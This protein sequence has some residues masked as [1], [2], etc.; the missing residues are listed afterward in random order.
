MTIK[1]TGIPRSVFFLLF[2][3]SGFAGLIYESIWSHY[4]KLFLGHAAYAQTLVLAIFMG[5]MALGARVCAAYTQRWRN[6]LLG[7]AVAELLI[8]LFA[9]VFH[10]IFVATTAFAYDSV[11]PALGNPVAIDGFKWALAALL[12]LPQSVLL[13]MTFPLM[14]GGIIR[15]YPG[16]PGSSL[17]MLY[18]TNSLGAAIG[19]LASGFY[20]LDKVGMPGTLLTA[21]LMNVGLALCVWGICKSLAAEGAPAAAPQRPL[22]AGSGPAERT[23]LYMML[24][25]SL[26]S[27]A[28]SFCYEIGWI[29]MLSLVLGSSTHAFEL[30]LSAFILGIAFGGLWIKKR[31]D[32]YRSIVG[33]L[34]VVLVAKGVLALATLPVYANTFEVMRLTMKSLAKTDFAYTVFNLT[35]HLISLSVMF[36]AAF[37][38]GMSLP[39]ITFALLSKG[40]GESSIGKVYAWNTLGAI[41]GVMFAVHVAMPFMGLKALIIAGAVADIAVALALMWKLDRTASSLKW[42]AASVVGVA[43]TVLASTLVNFDTVKMASGVYRFGNIEDSSLHQSVFHRDGKT[44]TIDVVRQGT[45]LS[46]KT[47]GKPDATLD[48][49]GPEPTGDDYTMVLAAALPMAYLPDA[50]TVANIGF[51]SGLTT[52]MLLANPLIKSVDT[53]E[54]EPA[55]VEG[56]RHFGALVERAYTDPRSTIYIDDAKS[57]FAG[58]N[59][60]YDVIVS[61]PSNPWVS[62]VSSLFS[63]EFY[64]QIKRHIN[65]GGMLVQWVQL[66]EINTELVATILK[67]LGAHFSDYVVYDNN[68]GDL[69]ILA[70]PNGKIGELDPRGIQAPL[71][72]AKLATIGI[73]STGELRLQKVGSK[74]TLHKLFLSYGPQVNSDYY[75]VVDLQAPKSRFLQNTAFEIANLTIAAVPV[76]DM[77]EGNTLDST[78]VNAARRSALSLRVQKSVIAYDVREYFQSGAFPAETRLND[79]DRAAVA[80][81]RDKLV[82]CVEPEKDDAWFELLFEMAQTVSAHLPAA[83]SESVW[84]LIEG[85]KCFNRLS[86]MQREWIAL[87]R[88]VGNRNAP[89]MATLSQRLLESG[90]GQTLAQTRYLVMAGMT[91]MIVQKDKAAALRLW[92]KYAD[93]NAGGGKSSLPLR[94]LYVHSLASE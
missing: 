14:S 89:A 18:F 53:V 87:F 44:A 23:Y 7:Y 20:L 48:P 84:Q 33:V 92:K 60:K 40:Y 55:M 68:S 15:L 67:A 9:L 38:A 32:G 3:V 71:L 58:R 78:T 29:R 25:A 36:P 82:K 65:D 4:L 94:L 12:I 63:E 6:L 37:C 8:G 93:D 76:M 41:F 47:N 83:E 46:I 31:I 80:Y 19:V 51:G 34:G 1:N 56:A 61:E 22:E 77:L 35:S 45:A 13:G 28:A 2:T 16:T 57:F 26:I 91:G 52:H 30:M 5:G 72:A 17:S 21:G 79:G 50:R 42:Q 49:V 85:S 88:N 39:L 54:I 64:T 27:G 74:K 10:W 81:V 59:S 11:F 43:A 66:Y 69:L 24:G 62:G 75:P 70:V 90:A 73:Q 86:D